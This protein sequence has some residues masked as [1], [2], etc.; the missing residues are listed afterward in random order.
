MLMVET[1]ITIFIALLLLA[2][3]AGVALAADTGNNAPGQEQKSKLSLL[4]RLSGWE[5]LL[6]EREE[7]KELRQAI[8]ADLTELK[9]LV[10]EARENKD[11]ENLASLKELRGQIKPLREEIK[12]LEAEKK[13][14]W[15]SLKEAGLAGDVPDMRSV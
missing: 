11:T 15:Q 12:Q 2:G 8:K 5:T 13:A 14:A 9:S 6:S 10:R 7:G 1:G 4:K 3:L